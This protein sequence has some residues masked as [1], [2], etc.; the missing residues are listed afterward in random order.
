MR[1]QKKGSIV[2][3]ASAAGIKALPGA[4]AYCVSKAGVCMLTRV[5]ALECAQEGTQIRVNAV[6]PGGVATPIWRQMP[7]WP[8]LVAREGSEE[9]ALRAL[10]QAVPMK[11]Y[12]EPAEIARAVLYLASDESAYVTGAELVVDGGF[13]A[14]FASVRGSAR[15]TLPG[16]RGREAG[17]SRPLL[18]SGPRGSVSL[19][20]RV[21][22]CDPLRSARWFDLAGE[23]SRPAVW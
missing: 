20:L 8:D 4:S 5:A 19:P 2:N 14:L 16:T 3:I 12:A 21:W 22:C 13:S 6:L 15:P 17:P 1:A 11:R 7:T 9:G 18:L 10:A 23:R